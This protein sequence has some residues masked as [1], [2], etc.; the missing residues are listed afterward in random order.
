[1]EKKLTVPRQKKL[2]KE[3]PNGEAVGRAFVQFYLDRKRKIREIN[4]KPTLTID[5]INFLIKTVHT[6]D[7]EELAKPYY[8]LE[9]IL[10]Q[11]AYW[12]DH[13]EHV[14]YHGLFRDLSVIQTPDY[15]IQIY[16]LIKSNHTILPASVLKNLLF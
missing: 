8:S 16:H 13:Y 7:D 3:F 9:K 5:E 4:F 10:H 1:M 14:Y 6:P 11:F 15:D 12:L 2:K